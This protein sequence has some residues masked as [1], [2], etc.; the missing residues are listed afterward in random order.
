M[1]AVASR[2]RL[3]IMFVYRGNPYVC[4]T[5]WAHD[6]SIFMP[7]F[8]SVS[9]AELRWATACCS[10]VT[11]PALACIIYPPADWSR[12]RDNHSNQSHTHT[13][14][15]S[16]EKH[17][18]DWHVGGHCWLNLSVHMFWRIVCIWLLKE[19]EMRSFWSFTRAVYS[20][21]KG[22]L[23]ASSPHPNKKKISLCCLSDVGS[24]TKVKFYWKA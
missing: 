5:A 14:T 4:G 20:H 16:E 7:L 11:T 10:A 15:H 2:I 22:I 21:A 9:R 13:H 8:V 18:W 24:V 6:I 19:R 1:L 17:Q 3:A 12:G 23:A